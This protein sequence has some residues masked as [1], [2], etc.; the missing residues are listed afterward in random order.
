MADV[1]RDAGLPHATLSRYLTLLESVFLVHRLPAWSRNFGQRLVKAPKIHLLDTGLASHLIGADAQ[2]LREDRMLFGRLLESFVVA[3]L[4][5]QISWTDA[6][7]A[8][9]HFRTSGG[10]EV[11]VVLEKPDGSVA[12][13]EIK[14]G[15]TVG[16]ADFTALTALKE[17]LDPHFRAGAVL[18]SGDR[19]LPFG[20]RLW[21]L[22]F[23]VLWAA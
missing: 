8:L 18:Y 14:A 9:H 1:G 10:S 6:R 19:I 5:K 17:K 3:E 15:A 16:A 13:I 7:I 21:L 23:S 22:P 20:D 11:D 12:A 2:R 4:R